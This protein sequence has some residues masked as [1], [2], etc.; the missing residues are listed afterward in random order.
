AGTQVAGHPFSVDGADELGGL[1]LA[2]APEPS[3]A[4]RLD[5]LV[6]S[7]QRYLTAIIEGTPQDGMNRIA[8]R[9]PTV[10]L[11]SFNQDYVDR[12]LRPADLVDKYL[13]AVSERNVRLLYLRPYTT[14][15][16]GDPLANT[17]R[18]ISALS[19]ALASEGYVV[20]PLASLETSYSTSAALRF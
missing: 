8:S 1:P 7:S 11:L 17:E 12:R 18:M 2:D 16:L 15:E 19:A 13:L 10:R 4:S 3:Q 5:E 9:V 14:T 20:E 6:E